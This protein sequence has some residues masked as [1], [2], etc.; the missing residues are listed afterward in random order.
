MSSTGPAVTKADLA[1][2]PESLMQPCA[3]PVE[4]PT[5]PLGDM[6]IGRDW[7][8]D[9]LSLQECGTSKAALVRAVKVQTG[10]KK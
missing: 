3:V 6:Q 2:I 1:A 10:A 9:R 5:G 8:A 7:S 4:L